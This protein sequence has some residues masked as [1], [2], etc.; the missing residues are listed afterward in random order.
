[1]NKTRTKLINIAYTIYVIVIIMPI[2]IISAVGGMIYD[3]FKRR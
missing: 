3:R 1:M 2:V